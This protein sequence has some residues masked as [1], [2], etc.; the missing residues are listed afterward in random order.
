MIIKYF[1]GVIPELKNPSEKE[2]NIRVLTEKTIAKYEELMDDLK[3]TEALDEV[4]ELLNV[5]N[6]YIEETTPWVLSKEGRTE[7][8]ANVMAALANTILVATKLL[9]PVLVESAPKVYQSFG[10]PE[11]LQAY[12][13]IHQFC[14]YTNLKVEKGPVLFPRLDVKVETD[15]IDSISK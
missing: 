7:E 8:L 1:D 10:V 5:A 12:E 3:P 14:P 2:E 9:S 15:Y 11:K 6:K 13:T 4:V